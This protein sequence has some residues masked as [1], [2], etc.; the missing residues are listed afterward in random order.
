[1]GEGKGGP[2]FMKGTCIID[3]VEQGDATI[4][5]YQA[6]IQIGGPLAS[7]GQRL[8]DAATNSIMQ[9]GFGAFNQVLVERQAAE[10]ASA[11]ALRQAQ[12]AA[13]AAAAPP[14]LFPGW[15][16]GA[17]AVAL[18]LLSLWVYFSHP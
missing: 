5:N 4:V 1:V 13:L 18:S 9:Q 15:V 8:V 17:L 7:V 14:E 11:A 10:A 12:H 3:A 6:T 2:G 16:A